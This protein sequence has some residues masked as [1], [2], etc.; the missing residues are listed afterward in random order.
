MHIL[1]I[2]KHYKTLTSSCDEQDFRNIMKE[3]VDE[4]QFLNK[5]KNG[6]QVEFCRKIAEYDPDFTKKY[7]QVSSWYKGSNSIYLSH[8][9]QLAGVK[10]TRALDLKVYEGKPH[11]DSQT[12]QE[13]SPYLV[14]MNIRF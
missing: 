7:H 6:G 11:E 8:K 12:Y 9:I 4:Y 14:E 3:C 13:P 1:V 5:R 2:H 10:W